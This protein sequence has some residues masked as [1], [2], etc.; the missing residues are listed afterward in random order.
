MPGVYALLSVQQFYREMLA[1]YPESS[2]TVY[3]KVR[4]VNPDESPLSDIVRSPRVRFVEEA[5]V[6]VRTKPLL[7]P[8]REGQEFPSMELVENENRSL[9]EKGKHYRDFL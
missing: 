7:F 3:I 8:L 5:G 4:L 2:F 9:Q 1:T 6:Y